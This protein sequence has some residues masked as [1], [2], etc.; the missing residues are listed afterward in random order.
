MQYAALAYNIVVISTALHVAQLEP[1]SRRAL[2]MER[3]AISALLPGPHDWITPKDAWYLH[4]AHG[5]SKSFTSLQA[6]SRAAQARVYQYGCHFDSRGDSPPPSGPSENDHDQHKL[7]K[8]LSAL[9]SLVPRLALPDLAEQHQ[10]SG[11]QGDNSQGHTVR[12]C[13]LRAKAMGQ[14]RQS[15]AEKAIPEMC[16]HVFDAGRCTTL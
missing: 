7:S 14:P 2:R 13:R 11:G 16:A 3:R 10:L 1:G 15:E 8:S 9:A 6:A 5:Q 4:D 12:H